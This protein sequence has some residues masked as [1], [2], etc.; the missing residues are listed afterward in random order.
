[1]YRNIESIQDKVEIVN[2]K[3]LKSASYIIKAEHRIILVDCGTMMD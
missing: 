1:M 3:L 2:N